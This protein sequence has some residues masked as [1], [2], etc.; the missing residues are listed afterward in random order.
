MKTYILLFIVFILGF[1]FQIQAQ[2]PQD[3]LHPGSKIYTYDSAERKINCNRR[4]VLVYLP[5]PL[6][7]GTAVLAFGHGQ[8]LNE[9]HYIQTYVH[10]AKKGIAVVHTDY[11]TGFFDTNWTRMARDY[12]SQLKC[13]LDQIPELNKNAVVYSGHSKGAYVAGV[14]AGLAFKENLNPKPA[15]VLLLNSAGLDLNALNFLDPKVEMTVVFS[16]KDSI[17]DQDISDELYSSSPSLRKQ[18]IMVKSYPA[19]SGKALVA[20][21]FWPLT[22][23]SLLGGT[24]ENALHYHSLWKW[25]VAAAQDANN[26]AEGLNPFLYGN[27]TED[28]GLDSLTDTVIKNF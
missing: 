23:R 10:L 17:V 24:T 8:S 19:S 9:S 22:K 11:S 26:G 4:Q 27:R 13:V 5:Q 15:S 6:N 21:H 1:Q 20:N 3:A 18:F 28:K 16:D 25:L 7:P 2:A 14:A 12:T